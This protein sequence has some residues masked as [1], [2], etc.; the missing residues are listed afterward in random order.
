MSLIQPLLDECA[1]DGVTVAQIKEKF[2]G[3]RFY[4]HGGSQDL[5]HRIDAAE[6]ASY[7]I[8][9]KCG[10]PGVLRSGGWLKTLCDTH[11]NERE[12]MLKKDAEERARAH[13]EWM[14]KH[15]KH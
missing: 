1:R 3:L 12:E 14:M 7:H 8:C 11:H 15:G 13:E 4:V 6:Q 9:E 10:A 2:G 5:W